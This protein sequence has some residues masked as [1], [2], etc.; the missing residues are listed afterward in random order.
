MTEAAAM[1][2]ADPLSIEG[3]SDPLAFFDMPAVPLN[4]VSKKTFAEMRKVTPAAVS[5]W[6][7]KGLPVEP[8]GRIAIDKADAWIKDNIDPSRR[9]ASLD[10]VP[11]EPSARGM[12]TT[13]QARLT[14]LRAEKLSGNLIDKRATLRQVEARARIERDAWIGWV[15]R[16]A[17]EIAAATDAEIAVVVS[18]LDRLV[19][20]QLA[21]LAEMPVKGLT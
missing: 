20:E 17:P 4:V 19:R 10:N 12:L 16:A 9:R 14:G 6:I 13:Q 3:R 18:L 15:N 8:N 2:G 11:S 1:V 5:Q 21:T 7:A